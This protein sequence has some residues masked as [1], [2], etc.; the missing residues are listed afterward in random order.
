MPIIE[1]ITQI[2]Q[3]IWAFFASFTDIGDFFTRI[4]GVIGAWFVAKG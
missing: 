3:N 2:F 4:W 1:E